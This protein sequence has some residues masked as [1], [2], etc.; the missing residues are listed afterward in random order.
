MRSTKARLRKRLIFAEQEASVD[1]MI[2]E[3]ELH[4]ASPRAG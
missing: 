1:Q 4:R 2:A 3:P